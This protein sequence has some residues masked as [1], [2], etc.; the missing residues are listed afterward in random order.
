MLFV[1][2]ND[3]MNYCN[4]PWEFEV[5]IELAKLIKNVATSEDSTSPRK[6]CT[7][8]VSW[9]MNFVLD[10]GIEV[11]SFCTDNFWLDLQKIF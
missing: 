6:I 10:E 4:D 1:I 8:A 3:Q 5:D 11:E 9:E 7:V 2:I